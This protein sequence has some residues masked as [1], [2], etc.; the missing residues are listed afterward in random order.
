MAI[1]GSHQRWGKLDRLGSVQ[2]DSGLKAALN[3]TIE[4]QPTGVLVK[5]PTN[6]KPSVS[7]KA[8]EKSTS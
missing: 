7:Y 3:K 5:H 6:L 2:M 1:N 8:M 4:P